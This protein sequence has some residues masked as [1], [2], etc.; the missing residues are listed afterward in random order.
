MKPLSHI[1]LLL[2][3]FDLDANKHTEESLILSFIF[4]ISLSQLLYSSGQGIYGSRVATELRYTQVKPT[5]SKFL[6]LHQTFSLIL[7][8]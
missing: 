6:P 3:N 5:K 2:M 7:K 8:E 1:H 4:Y